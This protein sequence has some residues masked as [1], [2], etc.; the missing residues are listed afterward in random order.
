[1][2]SAARPILSSIAGAALVA[3]CVA[4]PPSI[5]AACSATS[6]S[7][8][9]LPTVVRAEQD[10]ETIEVRR[11]GFSSSDTVRIA[12]CLFDKSTVNLTLEDG[13]L[14]V[15]PANFDGVAS[16]DRVV[17]LTH[18]P[19]MADGSQTIVTGRLKPPAASV[20]ALFEDGTSVAAVVSDESYVVWW[21]GKRG[22]YTLRLSDASGDA[23]TQPPTPLST[24]QP[25]D[26]SSGPQP[27]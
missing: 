27:G 6:G 1:M 14:S 26:E 24:V 17:E 9:V 21:Y 11:G 16:I 23:I 10:W 20:V 3:S 25:I 7:A 8:G 22:A 12:V 4:P 5:E 15:L 18:G 13:D 19:Q 2:F